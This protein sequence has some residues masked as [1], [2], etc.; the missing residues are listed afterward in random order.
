MHN[1]LG[2]A[3]A[4]GML[5]YQGFSGRDVAVENPKRKANKNGTLEAFIA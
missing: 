3:N 2:R 4:L 5:A 1:S